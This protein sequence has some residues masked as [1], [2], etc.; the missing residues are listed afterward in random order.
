MTDKEKMKLK[1]KTAPVVPLPTMAEWS[2][3]HQ[4][5]CSMDENKKSYMFVSMPKEQRI[6]WRSQNNLWINITNLIQQPICDWKDSLYIPKSMRPRYKEYDF[7]D[8]FEMCWIGEEVVIHENVCII[9]GIKQTK[10]IL[11]DKDAY[12]VY[13]RFGDSFLKTSFEMLN[14]GWIWNKSQKPFGEEIK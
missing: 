9:S 4:F 8:D 10:L 13:H 11:S 1:E 14:E 2:E 12:E 3:L 5:P 6:E 7:H